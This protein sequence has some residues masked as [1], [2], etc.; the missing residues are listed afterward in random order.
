MLFVSPRPREEDLDEIYGHDY[1]HG[2]GQFGNPDGYQEHATG[3]LT[4]AR[5]MVGWLTSSC[6]ISRGRWLDIGC[7]PGYLVQAAAEAGFEA[8]GVDVS[9]EAVELGRSRGLKLFHSKAE[10]VGATVTG[11]FQVITLFDTLFHLQQPRIVLDQAFRLLASGGVLMAGPFDL[12]ANPLKPQ[13]GR[14]R[15]D[16]KAMGVP[17]HLSF[18]NQTS[19]EVLLHSLGFKNLRFVPMPRNP[20]EVVQRR[21]GRI[22]GWLLSL[23]KRVLDFFPGLRLLLHRVLARQV[24][25]EAGYVIA[26]RPGDR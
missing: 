10:K 15:L 26:V 9:V 6:K 20:G 14:E 5:L 21:V 16:P 8:L 4:R 12:H 25:L 7:G 2:T 3:Y 24:N 1:F 17:E 22:P 18:V 13:P 23:V 19:M 11:A